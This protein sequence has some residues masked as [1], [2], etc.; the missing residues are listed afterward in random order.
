MAIFENKTNAIDNSFYDL[1]GEKWY[2]AYDDP[3]AL[4]RAES[5]VKL[6]WIQKKIKA[7]GFGREATILDV[8]CGAGF[9]SNEL[10]KEGYVI[11]GL[12]QSDESLRVARR[13]DMTK[14]VQYINGNAYSL[15]F[16]DDHFDIVISVD[17]LEHIENPQRV[18]QEISRVLKPGGLFF[19]HTFNRNWISYFLV[20]KCV[21]WFVRN[22]PKNMHVLRL[23]LK[24][25]E[26]RDLCLKHGL[27]TR[28]VEGVRPVFSSVPL[29]N[30]L[31]GTVPSTME[32]KLTRSTLLSYIGYA[33]KT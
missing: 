25:D 29:H 22:T 2:S 5:K 15:P 16:M 4:L 6:R 10:A 12:D 17:F 18:I 19:Y 9:L 1:Y 11:T 30:Y 32:F 33:I 20:I 7:L 14:S 8:G 24:P 3:V 13:H 21:E 23:F 27:I 28:E 26:V 31:N